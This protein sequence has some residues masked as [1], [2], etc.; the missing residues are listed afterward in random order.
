MT[1]R[2]MTPAAFERWRSNPTAFIEEALQ[3]PE[4]GKP[5]RLL[6]AERAF[7]EHAFRTDDDGRLL[8]PEQLYSAPKKSGKTA[9]AAMHA[10]TTALLFGG[11]APEVICAANDFDQAQGRVFEAIRKIIE[12]SPLLRAEA[13]ITAD[14][15]TF[16]AIGATF[17][18]IPSDYAGA[19]GGN[20]TISVFD[21]LWAYTSE[22]S[23]RLWDELVP[24]PTRRI[25]C[26]LTV[27]Y[28]GFEGESKLL[29]GMY[30]RGLQQPCV[31][32]DLY[33]G[34][35]LL[36]FWTNDPI[37]PW[38]TQSWL[39]QMRQ[40]LRPNAFLR[41]LQNQFVTT[42]T[43]FV[44]LAWWDSCVDPNLRPVVI[45][46]KS[47]PVW[48][49]VDASTKHDTTAIVA[50]TF[51][52][53]KVRLV[54]HKVFKPSPDHPLGFEVTIEATV[55]DY[56][57]RFAVRRVSF[58]PWQMQAVAQRLKSSGVPIYEFPQT[59]PNLTA[60]GSCLF[61][62]IKAQ[63]IVVYT[64]DELRLAVQRTVAKETPR[65]IQLTK[66]K[67]SHKIDVVIALAMAALHA[68]EQASR[69]EQ[70]ISGGKLFSLQTGVMLT[71]SVLQ[72]AE[73]A[74]EKT[75]AQKAQEASL[76]AQHEAMAPPRVT[77]YELTPEAQARLEVFKKELEQKRSSVQF[78]GRLYRDGRWT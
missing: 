30:R 13:K 50:V 22:R 60:M 16:P 75:E 45:A 1:Q 41:M 17:V 33:A 72:G 67:S 36:M 35:G 76:R 69:P 46:D 15:I 23:H 65:G 20:P 5:Y 44:D 77:E 29:E 73:R 57:H 54:A 2:R 66:E 63:S 11:R 71:N 43:N 4:T 25:A 74:E 48:I 7:L 59:V 6:D 12:C 26:R 47:I 40:Q 53:K 9:F 52:A 49:G 10:L 39:D 28:A 62:L 37:A 78:H 70:L 27:T 61:D 31:G 56:C 51:A 18:A 64:D 14:K 58:D 42:E 55:R 21:E 32:V 68:V 24:P 8:Y 34:D 38:Q 3:D 19:A